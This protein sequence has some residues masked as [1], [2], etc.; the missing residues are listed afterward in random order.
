MKGEVILE[1]SPGCVLDRWTFEYIDEDDADNKISVI[2][3]GV[4]F[5]VGDTIKIVDVK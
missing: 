3:D 4:T 5:S 2:L 1:N